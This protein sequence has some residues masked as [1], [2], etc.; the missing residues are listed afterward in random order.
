MHEFVQKRVSSPTSARFLITALGT[1]LLS[2]FQQSATSLWKTAFSARDLDVSPFSHWVHHFLAIFSKINEFVDKTAF[3]A[4]DQH[5]LSFLLPGTTTFWRLLSKV[6]KFVQ[7]RVFSPRSVR[8][9]IFRT[10]YNYFLAIFR[11]VHE[12]VQCTKPRFLPEITP[13][14]HFRH[15]STPLFSNFQQNTR[16]C[17]MYKTEV[18]HPEISM[19]CHFRTGRTCFLAIFSKVPGLSKTTFSVRDSAR[20][21]ISLLGAHFEAIFIKVHGLVHNS[22]FS[23]RSARFA[24]FALGALLFSN[25]QENVLVC[26]KQRFQSY[27]RHVLSA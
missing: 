6:H 25:F 4:R 12:F 7:N 9:V 8:F 1:P 21:V 17:T 11:K 16:V 24:I 20:F 26:V 13:F 2:D 14:C 3:P 15:W 23:K 19:F 18:F 10:G 5:V 22:V 27:I